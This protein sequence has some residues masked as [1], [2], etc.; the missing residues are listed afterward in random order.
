MVSFY[1]KNYIVVFFLTRLIYPNAYSFH[2]QLQ[3][4]PDAPRLYFRNI[5]YIYHFPSLWYQEL[6]KEYMKRTELVGQH[7]HTCIP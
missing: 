3:F 5:C 4:T 2:S 7:F 1:K 6:F